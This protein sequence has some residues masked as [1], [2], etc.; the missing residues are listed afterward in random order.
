M[1]VIDGVKYSKI[2]KPK[3]GSP[4]EKIEAV[5]DQLKRRDDWPIVFK[6]PKTK[7][8]IHPDGQRETPGIH[9]M[10]ARA[11]FKSELGSS[12]IIFCDRFSK[13][14][15]TEKIEFFPPK[16]NFKETMAIGKED[17]EKAIFLIAFSGY[18]DNGSITLI[19]E[20]KD[21]RDK[22]AVRKLKAQVYGHI[23][24]HDVFKL[25][26]ND[27]IKIALGYGV[28]SPSFETLQNKLYDKVVAE[29]VANKTGFKNFIEAVNLGERVYIS[30]NV[31]LAEKKNF[32][33][34]YPELSNAWGY[35]DTKGEM[36]KAITRYPS[37]E[38]MHSSL[39]N[40]LA[41]NDDAYKLLCA[42]LGDDL[43]KPE[44]VEKE[45]KDKED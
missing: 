33:K 2:G 28:H 15:K 8:T 44:E 23:F 9:R 3:A 43:I 24:T 14:A 11:V 42:S 1:L 26:E 36:T 13:N 6:I 10:V 17:I 34:A 25:S 21:N 4:A 41:E 30:A 32:I 38:T 5:R 40:F 12:D 31:R 19:D 7:I 37:K 45:N 27:L 20:G 22:N 18:V 39:I 16:I 35:C 29:Q